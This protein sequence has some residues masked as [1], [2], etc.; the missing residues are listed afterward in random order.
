MQR[1]GELHAVL[2]SSS[3]SV[4]Q[5]RDLL[6]DREILTPERGADR[7][8]IA[9][10]LRGIATAAALPRPAPPRTGWRTT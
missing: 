2:Q 7:A 8:N 1:G 5:A 10:T 4:I 9:P 6:A 3:Q